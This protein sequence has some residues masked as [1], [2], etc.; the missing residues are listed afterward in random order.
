MVMLNCP[1]RPSSHRLSFPY[2]TKEI[3]SPGIAGALSNP[4]GKT[5]YSHRN[6]VRWHPLLPIIKTAGFLHLKLLTLKTQ[7]YKLKAYLSHS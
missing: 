5:A 6:L 3:L 1:D 4:N 7:P 2:K